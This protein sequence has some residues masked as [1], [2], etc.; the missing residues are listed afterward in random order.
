MGLRLVHEI[1]V[2]QYHGA[3]ALEPRDGGT[4][5]QVIVDEERLKLEMPLPT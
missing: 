3:L 4:L 5:A 1:V 2:R